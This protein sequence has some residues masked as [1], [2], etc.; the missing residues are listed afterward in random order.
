MFKLAAICLALCALIAASAAEK[1]QGNPLTC[2]A[3]QLVIQFVEA[4]ITNNV[5]GTRIDAALTRICNS[6]RLADWCAQNLLPLV[7]QIINA[8]T[9][10]EPPQVVCQQIRLCQNSR[11]MRKAITPKANPLSCGICQGVIQVIE[12]Q[13]QGNWSV[14]KIDASIMKICDRLKVGSW[15]QTNI[16][17]KI[18]EVLSMISQKA[19]PEKVCTKLKLCN[20]TSVAV[21]EVNEAA[22]FDLK[23]SICESVVNNARKSA[24]EDHSLAGL[25]RAITTA[26]GKVPFAKDICNAFVAPLVQKIA[27]DLIS[28]TDTHT[29][30]MKIK[31]CK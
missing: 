12:S 16:L 25:Q 5:T 27:Q 19:A 24:G 13:V 8:I 1:Q 7:P 10:K 9:Q 26:C 30:C 31:L 22:D 17:P 6:L 29:I 28:N 23:C 15:C 14:D 20:A 3:C 18:P 11:P 2:S 4:Q 21:D